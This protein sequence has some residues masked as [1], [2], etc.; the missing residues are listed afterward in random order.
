MV[1]YDDK[2]SGI[3]RAGTSYCCHFSTLKHTFSFCLGTSYS[4][5]CGK[6]EE[7]LQR[8]R[9]LLH[10]SDDVHLFI[11]DLENLSEKLLLTGDLAVLQSVTE[12]SPGLGDQHPRSQYNLLTN[13]CENLAFWCATGQLHPQD[14][15]AE[16]AMKKLGTIIAQALQGVSGEAQL[17]T[18]DIN[19][20]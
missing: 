18:K 16:A 4:Q 2:Y 11:N 12:T 5:P 15:Q 7:I 13:N 6:S 9:L 20:R 14:G 8:A 10:Y 19:K 17:D 1:R 3:K